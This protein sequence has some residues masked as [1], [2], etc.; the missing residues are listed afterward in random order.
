VLV[1]LRNPGQ[2][3]DQETGLLYNIA[4]YYNPQAGRY[5]SSDPIGLGGGLNTY[6]YVF[7]NPL[8]RIDPNGNLSFGQV[9]GGV[10]IVAG[11][12]TFVAGVILTP[13][14][15]P[16]GVTIAA[17]GNGLIQA[18]INGV[19]GGSASDALVVGAFGVAAIAGGAGIEFFAGETA[20]GGAAGL[21]L[22]TSLDAAGNLATVGGLAGGTTTD[23]SAA[24][25]APGGSTAG[26]GS[27]CP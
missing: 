27:A 12:V 23:T 2:Y 9:L 7:D 5:I 25:G 11:G 20:L 17:L 1:N 24:A 16:L 15:G 6:A 26:G 13:E 22:G 18:G 21:V 8:T 4:R 3:F 10:S 19:E 14:S